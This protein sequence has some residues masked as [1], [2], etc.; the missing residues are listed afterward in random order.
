MIGPLGGNGVG[1]IN[2]GAGYFA[3][4]WVTNSYTYMVAVWHSHHVAVAPIHG[5]QSTIT[6]QARAVAQNANLPYAVV[7]LQDNPPCA[8]W[9]DLNVT[10][11]TTV[12]PPPAGA[13]RARAGVCSRAT[14]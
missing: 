6:L 11:R 12:L 8:Q 3:Q 7:V 4:L 5:F 10:G 1:T 2:L 13:P 14:L 9:H